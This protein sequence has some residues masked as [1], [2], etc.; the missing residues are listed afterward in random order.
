MN[1]NKQQGVN[2]YEIFETKERLSADNTLEAQKVRN[3]LKN[4]VY[5]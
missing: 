2:M 4:I 5:I 3:T 1:K